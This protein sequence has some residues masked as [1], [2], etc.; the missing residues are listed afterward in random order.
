MKVG[1]LLFAF[2]GLAV[3]IAVFWVGWKM[4]WKGSEDDPHVK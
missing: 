1:Y 4:A 2:L 3:C